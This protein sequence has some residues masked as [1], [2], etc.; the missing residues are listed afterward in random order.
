MRIIFSRFNQNYQIIEINT[1]KRIE[2]SRDEVKDLARLLILELN[3][4]NCELND[5]RKVYDI[6]S[7]FRDMVNKKWGEKCKK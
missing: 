5:G 2:L 1:G 4:I 3:V 7:K 6:D